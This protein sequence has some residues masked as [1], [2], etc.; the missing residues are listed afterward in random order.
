LRRDPERRRR[1]GMVAAY[2]ACSRPAGGL[3]TS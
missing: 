2:V 3:V 1:N